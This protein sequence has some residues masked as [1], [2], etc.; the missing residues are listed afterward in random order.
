MRAIVTLPPRFGV[1][2][3]RPLR[4]AGAHCCSRSR[5]GGE[6][7]DDQGAGMSLVGARS[8]LRTGASFEGGGDHRDDGSAGYCIHYRPTVPTRTMSSPQNSAPPGPHPADHKLLS[9]AWRTGSRRGSSSGRPPGERLVETKLAGAGRRQPLAR[10][11][12]AP[13]SRRRGLVELV[14]RIGAQV[15]EISVK[16]ASELYACR[17]LIE[18]RCTFEA[19]DALGPATGELESIRAAMEARSRRGDTRRFLSENIAYFR[20]LALAAERPPPGVRRA[21]LDE[22]RSATGASWGTSP[23]T[24]RF[25]LHSTWRCM[26][27][28]RRRPGWRRRSRRAILERGPWRDP[29]DVR[30]RVYR[31]VGKA[32]LDFPPPGVPPAERKSVC[33]R[34][35]SRLPSGR[36]RKRSGLLAARPAR[37]A[38]RVAHRRPIALRTPRGGDQRGFRDR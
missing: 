23:T 28:P 24:A 16:D 7:D 31:A 20:A 37:V 21:D 8:L 9:R 34:S 35:S 11:E 32:P 13:H 29:V 12:A 17:L 1:A 18:P 3:S 30:A 10:A 5:R 14:P 4:R 22:S 25:R 33:W 15:A 27:R 19:V 38:I 36:A 26:M 2:E 6:S